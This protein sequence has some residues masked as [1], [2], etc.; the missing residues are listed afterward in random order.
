MV[1]YVKQFDK[2]PNVVHFLILLKLIVYFQGKF[3][4]K[5]QCDYL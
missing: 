1:V 2:T 3:Y 4:H 5:K